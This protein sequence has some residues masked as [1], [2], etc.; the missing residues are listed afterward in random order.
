MSLSIDAISI[1]RALANGAVIAGVDL[2]LGSASVEGAIKDG[3]VMA[4][5]S[6]LSDVIVTRMVSPYAPS[7][8]GQIFANAVSYAGIRA[9]M[10]DYERSPREI[11]MNF[12][13]SAGSSWAGSALVSASPSNPLGAIYASN[14]AAVVPPISVPLPSNY[15]SL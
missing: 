11:F 7:G 14:Q 10:S 5:A 8:F 9:V 1:P 15:A 4:G 13:T 12:V 2:A 3:G 6:V